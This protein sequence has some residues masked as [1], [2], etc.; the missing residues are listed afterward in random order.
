MLSWYRASAFLDAKQGSGSTQFYAL[1]WCIER[2]HYTLKSGALSV[3]KRQ[4]DNIHTLINA[5]AFYS[6]GA[7]LAV[8]GPLLCLPSCLRPTGRRLF[9]P[10][11]GKPVAPCHYSLWALRRRC[12][13]GLGNL[14]WL[15]PSQS[16]TLAWG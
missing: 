5:L 12:G 15:R 14:G 11:G 1:R 9:H 3:E 10:R 7:C 16:A 6:V 8:A 13:A 2:I 4:F